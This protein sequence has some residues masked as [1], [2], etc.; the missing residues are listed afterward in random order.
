MGIHD[1]SRVDDGIFHHF[2]YAW[3]EELTRSLNAGVLPPDYYALAEQHAA[4][5]ARMC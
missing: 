1:W 5:F 3:I 2:H 4:G